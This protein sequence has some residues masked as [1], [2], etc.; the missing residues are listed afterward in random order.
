MAVVGGD[1]IRK[2]VE[3]KNLRSPGEGCCCAYVTVPTYLKF[4]ERSR[5]RLHGTED[6]YGSL[7]KTRGNCDSSPMRLP[8]SLNCFDNYL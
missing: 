1:W 5:G 7:G 4:G 3:F 8:R 2:C 6:R